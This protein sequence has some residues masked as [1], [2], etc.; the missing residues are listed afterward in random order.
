MWEP[1]RQTGGQTTE[2]PSLLLHQPPPQRKELLLEKLG[3]A[4]LSRHPSCCPAAGVAPA[5]SSVSGHLVPSGSRWAGRRAGCS[6]AAQRPLCDEGRSVSGAVCD[7]VIINF[8]F[9]GHTAPG[10]SRP[11]RFWEWRSVRHPL[12]VPGGTGDL[13]ESLVANFWVLEGTSVFSG[14]LRPHPRAAC[15]ASPEHRGWS[16]GRGHVGLCR[17]DRRGQREETVWSRRW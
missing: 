16:S 8:H 9:N 6:R 15:Q 4:S 17:G 13:P 11:E 14:T 12:Q 3:E 5:P 1:G 7:G 2:T 10:S